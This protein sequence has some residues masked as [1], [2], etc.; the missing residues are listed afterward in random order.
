MRHELAY[1]LGQMQIQTVSSTLIELLTN[2]SEDVLV[3]HEVIIYLFFNIF[4][5]SFLILLFF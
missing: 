4:I 1:I 5:N 2:E 3:R